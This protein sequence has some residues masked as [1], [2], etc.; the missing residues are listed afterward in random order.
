MAATKRCVLRMLCGP[1]GDRIS[2]RI[3]QDDVR[4]LVNDRNVEVD[5]KAVVTTF[6]ELDQDSVEGWIKNLQW[7]LDS[8]RNPDRSL[9]SMGYRGRLPSQ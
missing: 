3:V 8:A 7:A 9:R 6:L 1:L 4:T 2:V 5:R